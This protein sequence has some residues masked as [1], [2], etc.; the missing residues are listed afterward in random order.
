MLVDV[1][2]VPVVKSDDFAILIGK[3]RKQE[4]TAYDLAEKSKTITNEL[5][6]RL[7]NRLNRMVV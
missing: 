4:I 6:S 3:S 1:T 7:G 2:D 5:L